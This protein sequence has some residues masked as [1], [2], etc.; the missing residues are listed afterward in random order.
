MSGN[1]WEV[2][3]SL[4]GVS[5]LY[6]I[7]NQ[8]SG[9]IF[10]QDIEDIIS[11]LCVSFLLL[12]GVSLLYAL[13]KIKLVFCLIPVSFGISLVPK[14]REVMQND[15]PNRLIPIFGFAENVVKL[16][17][18]FVMSVLTVEHKKQTNQTC[19]T[20]R[21]SGPRITRFVGFVA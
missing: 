18:I 11:K 16:I 19:P 7:L 6:L 1:P 15:F 9:G 14:C 5:L 2:I 12:A 4:A 8:F 17:T 21:C 20:S 3:F 10:S 13:T